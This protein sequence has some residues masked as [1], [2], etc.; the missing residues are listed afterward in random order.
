[1][2]K[3]DQVW[4]VEEEE[5]KDFVLDIL[6]LRDERRIKINLHCFRRIFHSFELLRPIGPIYLP[7][8]N[9]ESDDEFC[10]AFRN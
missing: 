2:T 6:Q 9:F 3:T 1:M 10:R 4:V 8:S 7:P 5:S